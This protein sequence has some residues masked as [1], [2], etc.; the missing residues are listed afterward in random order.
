MPTNPVE[1]SLRHADE[2]AA[3]G[4]C[5]DARKVLVNL[6]SQFPHDATIT[7]RCAAAHDNLGFEQE[8]ILLYETAIRLGLSDADLPLAVLGLGSSY[9]CVNNLEKSAEILEGGAQRFP[10]NAGI[11]TFLAM[12]YHE[13]GRHHLAMKLLLECL[14][15]TSL[16]PTINYCQRAIIDYAQQYG[17]QS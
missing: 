13:Q 17:K 14:A 16:D 7:Y 8:A 11:R 9:R 2:L 4:K 12:T 3:S 5:E 1:F 15:Q 6:C 10:E